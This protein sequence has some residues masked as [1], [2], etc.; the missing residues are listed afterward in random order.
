MANSLQPKPLPKPLCPKVNKF[1]TK[2]DQP[3]ARR[4]TMRTEQVRNFRL[5]RDQPNVKRL[6]TRADQLRTDHKTLR[7]IDEQWTDHV[8]KVK[9]TWGH[10][11]LTKQ[12]GI[13]RQNRK[14]NES[15]YNSPPS[16]RRGGK[17][18]G[19]GQNRTN[20]NNFSITHPRPNISVKR[21]NKEAQQLGRDTPQRR[22]TRN[23]KP[24]M[25]RALLVS[26]SV[27]WCFEPSQ[28][29]R[30]TSGLKNKLQFI[31]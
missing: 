5:E 1:L 4:R 26:Y 30:I 10:N 12:P 19:G 25:P 16:T 6:N 24:N 21:R 27:S 9:N 14:I 2:R 17:K 20:K 29:Q 7:S 28:P 13:E 23:A 31:S 15:E 11:H 3:L 22:D 18:G 8:W